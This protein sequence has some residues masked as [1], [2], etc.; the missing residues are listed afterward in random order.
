M[1]FIFYFLFFTTVLFSQNSG[2][3]T[4]KVKMPDTKISPNLKAEMLLKEIKEKSEKQEYILEFNA[5]QSHFYLNEMIQDES[6]INTSSSKIISVLIGGSNYYDKEKNTSINAGMHGIY[7]KDDNPNKDWVVTTESKLIDDYKCYKAEYTEIYK[8]RGVNKT[9][10]IT[11][12]FAPS[13]PYPFGPKGYN[14][15]PGL[16][17]ELEDSNKNIKV[18]VSKIEIK[19][20][21]IFIKFP[22]SEAISMDEYM[23]KTSSGVFYKNN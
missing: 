12:W 1:R 6:A 3:I 7:I 9:K 15:L 8:S 20:D 21:E 18:F 4:Y 16:I 10:I 22:K 23:S 2:V 13:L 14:G 19:K 11:A 5:N 17:L